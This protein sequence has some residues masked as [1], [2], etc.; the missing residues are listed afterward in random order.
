LHIIHPILYF[1]HTICVTPYSLYDEVT[2]IL[3]FLPKTRVFSRR[4]PRRRHSFLHP[5]LYFQHTICV[6]PHSLYDEV[7]TILFFLPKTRVF[8]R[9]IPRRRH[10]FY[11]HIT[12]VHIVTHPQTSGYYLRIQILLWALFIS[13]YII[14]VFA[15]YLKT[16]HIFTFQNTRIK[17]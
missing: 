15:I 2:T 4:I 10:S 5:I 7:T 12:I 6:T 17:H 8:S 13:I 3:F 1:Q 14:F 16:T 11:T 9:R